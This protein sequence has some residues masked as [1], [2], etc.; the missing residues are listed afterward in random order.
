MTGGSDFL[1]FL[2]EGI[3]SGGL[4]TG[5]GE[6]KTMEQRTLFGGFANAPLDPCYHQRYVVDRFEDG[7]NQLVNWAMTLIKGRVICCVLFA[8]DILTWRKKNCVCVCVER[9][10]E[11]WNHEKSEANYICRLFL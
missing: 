11:G 3:P 4:L 2:L 6:R 5:A 8:S 7:K 1:P 10:C 9:D